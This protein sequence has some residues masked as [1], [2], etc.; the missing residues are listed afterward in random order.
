MR[1][2]RQV[3]AVLL[4][5]G[6]TFLVVGLVLKALHQPPQYWTMALVVAT[7]DFILAFVFGR[8]QD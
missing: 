5:S 4:A 8:R 3:K 2:R 6:V 7:W 1:N